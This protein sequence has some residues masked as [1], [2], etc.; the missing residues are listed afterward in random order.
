MPP[1]RKGINGFRRIALAI[2]A[3]ID[4]SLF[5]LWSICSRNW[6]RYADFINHLKVRHPWR[7]FVDIADEALTIGLVGLC[8]LSILAIPTFQDVTNKWANSPVVTATYLDRYG[9]EIG[10]RGIRFDDSIK[11][12]DFPQLLIHAV[13]ATEDRR[14]YHHWGVDPIG[15]FRA[16]TVN[17][18]GGGVVQ[19]GSTIT[20]Q[21]AKNLFLSN[22]RSVER[23][24]R[25]AFLA[26]WL[27]THYSKNE[28]LK[29]YLDLAYMGGGSHGIVAAA[30]YYFGKKLPELSL[31]EAAM[32]A[33]LFK[34]PTKYSPLVNLPA[35]RG[36]ANDVLRNMVDA[37]Y[38]TE[39]QI[40]TALR[41]PATPIDRKLEN[42]PEYYLDWAYDQTRK[43]VATGILGHEHVLIIKTPFDRTIQTAAEQALENTLKQ[44]G[45]QYRVSQGA[46]VVMDV[47]GQVR[48]IVG[49][50][51]YGQSQFNRATDALRQPGSSF[52]PFVYA[53]ALLAN[54]KLSPTSRVVDAP[55]C[56]GNW[57]PSNYGKSYAGAMPMVSALARSINTVAVRLSIEAGQGNPKLGRKR[58]VD[59]AHN[60]GITS[61]LKDSASLPI[62]SGEVYVIDMAAA[63]SAFGNGGTKTT[64]LFALNIYTPDGKSVFQHDFAEK[65]AQ[66]LPQH[67]VTDMNFMLNKV[68]EAGT[69]RRAMIEGI[70]T[71]GKTG[72]TNEYRDAW[73]IGFTGMMTAAVWLGN[74]DHSSMNNLT[75]GILPAMI[76]H[77]TMEVALQNTDVKPLPGVIPEKPL[78]K[79]A[80]SK[81]PVSNTIASGDLS[82][83]SVEA[84][85]A[86]KS[87]GK[88]VSSSDFAP[89]KSASVAESA[90]M[91]GI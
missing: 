6:K 23:K 25:E 27:E 89:D 90:K 74:D 14:F 66:V 7:W 2:D 13:L 33:G 91:G 53:S 38:L 15:T 64:P 80:P 59:L 79:L 36:R 55:I 34:A 78:A 30:N 28:I 21:L 11:F 86:I 81:N 77:D 4:A 43:L 18:T 76:W 51:D 63:Y 41:N 47:D 44:Y 48:A 32:L 24:I 84:L 72:T 5:S 39:G 85:S 87:L 54:P 45:K 17:M 46:V 35:A 60:M 31:A 58:I 20:Q 67:V 12:E 70:P 8:F 37:G 57:C 71:G 68:V 82:Q 10:H 65:G 26:L 19:G 56:V 83:K 62:G 22:E 42:A 16:L 9:N 88:N 1:F 61:E 75:G 29:Q 3:W 50:R 73:F 40:Q 52:K 69:A 49:G